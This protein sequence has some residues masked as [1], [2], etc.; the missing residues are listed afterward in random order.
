MLVLNTGQVPWNLSRQLQVVYAP[1]VEEIEREVNFTRLL[2][3]NKQERRTKS[4]EFAPADLVE[5]FI[6]FGLRK[7]E[8]DTKE[9]L[10]DEFSRLDM[11]DALSDDHYREVFYPT[12]QVMVN[13]DCALSN[14][15][16]DFDK[17]N[18]S[19]SDEPEIQKGRGIFDRKPARIGFIVA[20]A[21]QILGRVGM[22][23]SDI[24]SKNTLDLIID[25]S[26]T[27]CDRLGSLSADEMVDFLKLDVL[28]ERLSGTKRSAVG[29][30]E[31]EY[32][33]RAFGVLLEENFDIPT[34]EPCWR[35]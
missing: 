5:L 28:E 16:G 31:R 11:A 4:G 32:F 17:D 29:R 25:G 6:A 8:Y 2:D 18:A 33:Q 12:V 35:A 14:R 20:A 7:T 23:K 15:D 1:I 22:T 19:G 26:G 10:A 27:F 3:P 24:E 34:M 13:L 9:T 30:F 21:V